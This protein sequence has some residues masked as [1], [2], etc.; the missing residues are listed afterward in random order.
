MNIDEKWVSV[1]NKKIALLTKEVFSLHAESVDRKDDVSRLQARLEVELATSVSNAT[2]AIEE[3]E[4]QMRAV[5]AD[6]ESVIRQSYEAQFNAAQQKFDDQR[7]R[8]EHKSHKMVER[9]Q[10]E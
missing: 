4:K 5:K 6:L 8:M 3:A 2:A 1:V 9:F 7:A 10:H